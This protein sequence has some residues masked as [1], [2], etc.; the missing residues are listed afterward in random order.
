MDVEKFLKEAGVDYEKHE[1]PVAYTAQELAAKEHVSGHTVAKSV[2]V[3]ADGRCVLCVLPASCNIDLDRL[4]EGLGP[5]SAYWPMRRTWHGCF[6]TWRWV[7]S[8]RSASP[9]DW[10]RWWT[11][12]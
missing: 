5:R 6:P 4:A 3:Y 7:R 12:I 2:A 9:T 10:I 8:R 11:L 1:H